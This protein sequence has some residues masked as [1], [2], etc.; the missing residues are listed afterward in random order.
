MCVVLGRGTGEPL[1]DAPSWGG[2]TGGSGVDGAPRVWGLDDGDPS[3]LGD[4]DRRLIREQVAREIRA[5]ASRGVGVGSLER[6]AG[7]IL[8]PPR[9][10]WRRELSAVM[11]G[12]LR[13]AGA[14]DY[15]YARPSRRSDGDII[16]P[17]LRGRRPQVAI[18]TDVSCSIGDA[19]LVLARSEVS[20]LAKSV[21]G[22]A[23]EIVCDQAVHD[24]RIATGKGRYE[25]G[26]GTD[27][28]VGIARAM[29]FRPAPDVVVV[30]TD[31]HTPWPEARPAA[32]VVVVLIGTQ[33]ATPT[34]VPRW[35]KAVVMP[36]Q[37]LPVTP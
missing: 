14:D 31:G 24:V 16:L 35:A 36:Q 10:D 20:A 22:E 28:G 5:A 21:G 25:G 17:A 8:A 27:M 4:M 6:W 32:R 30:L 19:E 13:A 34:T 2:C 9:I 11:R 12:E 15:T 33:Q 18:V 3:G 29:R 1:F 37:G 23:R 7:K 26:G